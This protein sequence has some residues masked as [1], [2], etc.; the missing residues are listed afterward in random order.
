MSISTADEFRAHC[1][2]LEEQRFEY[3]FTP[4]DT[5]FV[6]ADFANYHLA[7]EW[8]PHDAP[9][10]LQLPS[11]ETFAEWRRL[12]H[13]QDQGQTFAAILSRIT[14]RCTE[15]LTLEGRDT[16]Y[17][18]ESKAERATRKA[19]EAQSRFRNKGTGNPE[20][21]AAREHSKKL[22]K[23]Y[24]ELCA[25]RKQAFAQAGVAINAAYTEYE[26]AAEQVEALQRGQP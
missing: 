24:Q 23:K 8:W 25:A 7:Q 16:Q 3:P 12:T 19:R 9:A 5:Y 6:D 4:L 20:L 21:D 2:L 10:T 26:Q 22:Y 13:A 14:A 1:K 11:L 18:N 15:W 17:P